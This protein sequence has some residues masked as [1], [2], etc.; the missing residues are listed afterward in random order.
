MR[1]MW[2]YLK[3]YKWTALLSMV[4][5][6]IAQA[7]SFLDPIMAQWG[8]QKERGLEFYPAGSWGPEA[9]DALIQKEGRQWLTT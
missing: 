1:I 7:L 6:A 2:T 3:P 8:E 5:A 4:L 9:A